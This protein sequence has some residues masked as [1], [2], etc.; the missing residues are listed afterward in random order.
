MD[1][2]KELAATGVDI[3]SIGDL[4]HSVKSVDISMDII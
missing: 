2:V 1:S 4:T 3:I